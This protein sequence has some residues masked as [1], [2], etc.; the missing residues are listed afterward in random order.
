MIS[1]HLRFH[2]SE[3]NFRASRMLMVMNI[4]GMAT[5]NTGT[6]TLLS[7][8]L[9]YAD[10]GKTLIAQRARSITFLAMVSHAI[11]SSNSLARLRPPHLRTHRQR[12]DSEELSLPLQPCHLL[13]PA[14]QRDS[15]H[16]A[17]REYRRQGNLLPDWRSPSIHGSWLQE[18]RRNEGYPETRQRGSCSSLW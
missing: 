7:S 2:L 14:G 13:P 10:C 15:C 4:S 17:R 8:S 6:A 1:S 16:L 5:R 11:Q 3:Q 18:G 12:R 9:S